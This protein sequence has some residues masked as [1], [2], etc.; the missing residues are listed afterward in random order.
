MW[1]YIKLLIKDNKTKIERMKENKM[2][3]IIIIITKKIS[4]CF[5]SNLWINWMNAMI[6]II[7]M[8]ESN[9]ISN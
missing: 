4:F 1:P 5:Y 8:I 6:K 2:G 3:V 9:I 7:T